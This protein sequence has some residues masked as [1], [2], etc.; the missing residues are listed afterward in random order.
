MWTATAPD[1][2]RVS[3]HPLLMDLDDVAALLRE[4]VSTVGDRARRGDIPGARVGAQWRFWRPAVMR[5]AVGDVVAA[6]LSAPQDDDPELVSPAEI[7]DLLGISMATTMTLLHSGDIPAGRVGGR[8]H[9]YWP[10][11]RD[12]IAEGHPLAGEKGS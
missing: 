11:I 12:A 2:E 7:A 5:L 10:A 9:I 1:C 4:H 6:R 8:W 3:M